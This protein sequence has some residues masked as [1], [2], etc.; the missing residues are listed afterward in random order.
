MNPRYQS[1]PIDEPVW[2]SGE[3]ADLGTDPTSGAQ[4]RRLTS[5]P[6]MNHLIYC[7]QP[8]VS[9][10]GK[11]V[12]LIRG[13]DFTFENNF[14][15][16]VAEPDRLALAMVERS[17]PR[18]IVHNSWSEWL[19]YLTHEGGLRRFSLVTLA[20]EQ[21]LPDGSIPA[22]DVQSITPDNRHI[23]AWERPPDADPVIVS[24]DTMTAGRRVL[25][26]H[27]DNRNP[28]LQVEPVHGKKILMQLVGGGRVPVLVMNIDGSD[29]RHLPIGGKFT[30]ESSGHMSWIAGTNRAAVCVEWDRT[31]HKHDPRHP[32]GNLVIAGPDD[33]TPTVFAAPE[34]AVYH[35]SV[36]KCGRYFVADDFM[37]FRMDAFRGKFGPARLVVGSIKTGKYRVLVTDCMAL[38][39]AGASNWEPVPYFTTDNRYV[40]FNSSPFGTNQVHAAQIPDGFLRELD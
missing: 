9:P 21:V 1:A 8:Y 16:L 7:E 36:S 32:H 3:G 19:Y 28:H 30:K 6:L 40:I 2:W 4:I 13:R 26:S 24:Y 35:V 38:G 39:L 34:H 29:V 23:I 31:A 22:T 15:L 25:F 12:A 5:G 33:K 37:D 27:K 17:I 18:S 10:D 20:K 14:S 11:R